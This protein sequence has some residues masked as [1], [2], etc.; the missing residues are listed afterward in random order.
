MNQV[1]F[2]KN[3]SGVE[4]SVLTL[5]THLETQLTSEITRLEQSPS[6]DEEAEEKKLAIYQQLCASILTSSNTPSN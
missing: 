5:I 2:I 3:S 4:N 1:N 6:I